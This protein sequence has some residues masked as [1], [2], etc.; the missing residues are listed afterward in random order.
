MQLLGPA[1]TTGIVGRGTDSGRAAQ[2]C[3]IH[4]WA[5]RG[6]SGNAFLSPASAQRRRGC[7]RRPAAFCLSL[8]C[9][10]GPWGPPGL[11]PPPSLQRRTRRTVAWPPARQPVPSRTGP[12]HPTSQTTVFD[13]LLHGCQ[14]RLLPRSAPVGGRGTRCLHRGEADGPGVKEHGLQS[15]GGIAG[16]GSEVPRPTGRPPPGLPAWLLVGRGGGRVEGV[17][18]VARA[19]PPQPSAGWSRLLWP[20]QGRL[21]ASPP[22]SAVPRPGACSRLLFSS[23]WPGP[24][25]PPGFPG[26]SLALPHPQSPTVTLIKAD[27]YSTLSRCQTPC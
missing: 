15:G 25:R 10:K 20:W 8:P 11:E 12:G 21:R 27:V 19:P 22:A 1:R 14:G 9:C 16:P 4:F 17:R 5:R 13:S 6:V 2:S 3:L 18:A 26:P 23:R 24:L 7:R